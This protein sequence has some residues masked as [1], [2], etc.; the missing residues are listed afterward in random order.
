M[1]GSFA[2]TR[3][4]TSVVDYSS[5][6]EGVLIPNLKEIADINLDE[7]RWILVIEKEVRPCIVLSVINYYNPLTIPGHVPHTCIKPVL[8]RLTSRKGDTDH[9]ESTV[10][11]FNCSIALS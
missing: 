3:K 8:E 11:T 7:V 6:P 9:G 5:E 2:I 4:D 1:V 10:S